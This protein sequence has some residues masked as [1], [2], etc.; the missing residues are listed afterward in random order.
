MNII[1]TIYKKG[2]MLCSGTQYHG[3]SW[4]TVQANATTGADAAEDAAED[5]D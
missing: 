2:M 3:S 4:A 5:V 1:N